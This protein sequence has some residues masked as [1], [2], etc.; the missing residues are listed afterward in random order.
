MA[1]TFDEWFDQETIDACL[2]LIDKIGDVPEGFIDGMI[3]GVHINAID[4]DFSAT[5]ILGGFRKY[6]VIGMLEDIKLSRMLDHPD[7]ATE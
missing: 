6:T 3:F 4:D 1:W 2:V 7:D 5:K